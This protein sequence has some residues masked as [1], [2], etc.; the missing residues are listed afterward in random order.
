MLK[1]ARLF[2]AD[3][4]LKG[5]VCRSNVNLNKP[6]VYALKHVGKQS[7][8]DRHVP[9][10]VLWKQALRGSKSLLINNAQFSRMNAL[11]KTFDNSQGCDP[12]P[13]T[14]MAFLLAALVPM[15]QENF[16]RT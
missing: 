6:L 7:G 4:Q 10:I 14:T 5:G 12:P 8:D 1:S 11:S 15:L 2:D 9:T 13:V 16:S 3:I